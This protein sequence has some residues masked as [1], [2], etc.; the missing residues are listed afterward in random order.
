MKVRFL[1]VTM[2]DGTKWNVPVEAIARNHAIAHAYEFDGDVEKS[3]AQGTMPLFDS[4]IAEIHH[5]ASTNMDWRDVSGVARKVHEPFV[6]YQDGWINGKW[7]VID[8]D[9]VPRH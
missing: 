4:D 6:D 1:Q 5:W 2:P 7:K 9:I 3:L 8:E